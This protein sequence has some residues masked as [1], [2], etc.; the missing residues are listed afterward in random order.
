M[1]LE[2]LNSLLFVPFQ[3]GESHALTICPLT[4]DWLLSTYYFLL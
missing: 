2:L 4:D 3:A 1:K